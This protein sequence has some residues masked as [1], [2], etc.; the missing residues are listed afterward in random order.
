TSKIS[1][2]RDTLTRLPRARIS[3]LFEK[4][5]RSL[6]LLTL[7]TSYSPPKADHRWLQEWFNPCTLKRCQEVVKSFG[8]RLSAPWHACTRLQTML[9]SLLREPRHSCC[10]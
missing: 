6:R 7:T 8:H 3:W 9:P 5:I 2:E 1:V 4:T 10:D